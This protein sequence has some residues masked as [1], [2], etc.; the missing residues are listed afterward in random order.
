MAKAAPSLALMIA[1][2]GK[3]KKGKKDDEKYGK[4]AKQLMADAK[5]DD[6]EAFGK[7]LREFI[8]VTGCDRD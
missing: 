8:T 1:M 6:H 7:G 5:A 2:K 3:P 4:M